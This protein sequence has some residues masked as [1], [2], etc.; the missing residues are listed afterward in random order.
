MGSYFWTCILHCT[1]LF[2]ETVIFFHYMLVIEYCP[3]L[4]HHSL[5]KIPESTRKELINVVKTD[6]SNK[7]GQQPGVAESDLDIVKKDHPNDHDEQLSDI[8]SLHTRQS[9]RPLWEEV[10]TALWDIGEKRTA[11]Q[12]AD[13]YGMAL[14]MSSSMHQMSYM[15]MNMI[16]ACHHATFNLYSLPCSST[17][18]WSILL[19]QCTYFW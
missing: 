3:F 8:L 1:Q 10:A 13:E 2:G 9:V 17:N 6:K 15:N 4:P 5:A 11:Q 14:F 19:S 7:L 16:S 12:I 18:F